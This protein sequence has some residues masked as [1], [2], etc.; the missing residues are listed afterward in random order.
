ML[1]RANALS[2]LG[3][4]GAALAALEPAAAKL[5]HS[6]IDVIRGNALTGLKRYQEALS[7]YDGAIA[8]APGNAQALSGRG[9]VLLE[10]GTS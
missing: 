3:L 4:Y 1:N 2:E 6:T 5:R 7:A 10:L 8:A 9:H